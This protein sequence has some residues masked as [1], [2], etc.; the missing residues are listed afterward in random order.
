[1]AGMSAPLP[2]VGKTPVIALRAMGDDRL[3]RLA[4]AGSERAFE[5]I[6]E[7]HYQELY[8]YCRSIL[9]NA[10]D[11]ADALQNTMASALRALRGE[12]REI[13][14][15]PWL[16]RIAHNESVSLLRRRRTHATIDESFEL[17]APEH[18]PAVR[19]RLRELVADLQE[20][21]DI[22]RGALVM[23]ELSGLRYR[24]IGEALGIS[25]KH[26]RQIVYEARGALHDMA[27]GRDMECEAI[28]QAIS[29][30]DGRVMRGR[31]IR[32]HM[33]TCAGCSGFAELLGRRQRDLAAIAPP[34][35]AAV[36]AGL[37]H[38]VLGGGASGGGAA[39]ASSGGGALGTGVVAGKTVAAPILTKVGAV[40]AMAA[41]AGAGTVEIARNHGH[42]RAAPAA[43]SSPAA[44]HKASGT[45]KPINLQA[46]STKPGA[47]LSAPAAVHP[48][49]G[50]GR[51]HSGHPAHPAHP[52]HPVH[53]PQS[54][55]QEHPIHPTHPSHP[56]RPT[57]PVH[58]AHPTH[59]ATPAPSQGKGKT[60]NTAPK[61]DTTK[62]PP[63]QVNKTQPITPVLPVAP[64]AP[65]TGR[66][67]GSDV[68][69]EAGAG[70]SQG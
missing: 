9:G 46:G 7:R 32:A 31:R 20:L 67:I 50:T 1:M 24:E 5:V 42:H 34:L 23:H 49:H 39:A 6:Y 63:G 3:V 55:H 69:G 13:A 45:T 61:N 16:F 15:R 17:E 28:R 65:A 30:N 11:A 68:N 70:N 66:G 29:D 36:A 37:L 40:V 38:Q 35:P 10:E 19:Q 62:T 56:T 4:A 18:D 64:T 22:Q 51:G 59:P 52:A 58:P 48:N 41:L 14:V 44:A 21:P 57:H 60:I 27:G 33:R 54:A 8:R 43:N 25:E 2:R 12:R 47:S 26:A 53:P